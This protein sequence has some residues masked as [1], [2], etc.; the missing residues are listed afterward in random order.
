MDKL[1]K[2]DPKV[3]L[4]TGSKGGCGCSFIASC[5]STYFARETEKNILLLDLNIGKKDSR[6]IFNLTDD[7]YRDIG[8]IE[9]VI[10]ELDISILKKLVINFGN[11]LNLILPPI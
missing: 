9:E 1:S 5:V 2:R 3:V 11:S 4:F 10:D 8:D 7:D 6:L